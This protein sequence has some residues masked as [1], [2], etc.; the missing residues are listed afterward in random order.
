MPGATK[1]QMSGGVYSIPADSLSISEGGSMTGGAY[2]LQ[3]SGNQIE[4]GAATGGAIELQNG[5]YAEITGDLSLTLDNSSVS[6]GTMSLTSVNSA[7]LVATVTTDSLSGYAL[8]I[9]EDG[10]LRSGSNDINDVGDGTVTA[11]SEEYG[12]RTSGTNGQLN[13]SDSA[14]N[15]SVTVASA[16]APVENDQ[17]T[18]SFKASVGQ[19]TQA[20][21]YSQAITF[22]LTVNP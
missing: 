4:T 3:Q 22:T 20:G 17:T 2:D 13:S 7:S 10:N 6:L 14:I 12:I 5:F 15:S 19:S 16:T 8:A 1:S 18:I 11:G 9:S 21:S